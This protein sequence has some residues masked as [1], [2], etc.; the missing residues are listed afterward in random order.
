[1]QGVPRVTKEGI[2]HDI[3]AQPSSYPAAARYCTHQHRTFDE[4]LYLPSSVLSINPRSKQDCSRA[5]VS[6]GNESH[7]SLKTGVGIAGRKR[8]SHCFVNI[9]LQGMVL[10]ELIFWF[11][12]VQS[13]CS[14]C[15]FLASPCFLSFIFL[16]DSSGFLCFASISFPVE[17]KG[18]TR[19]MLEVNWTQCKIVFIRSL[20]R[21]ILP[22]MS[23]Q[24]FSRARLHITQR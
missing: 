6:G 4:K 16:F 2:K 1:M 15:T 18:K 5:Q 22:V 9:L 14:L 11:R 19:V 10:D 3:F 17:S 13:A 23:I 21:S 7:R 20:C 24:N 8:W 12:V